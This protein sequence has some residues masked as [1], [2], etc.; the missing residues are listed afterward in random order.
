[1]QALSPEALRQHKGISFVGVT[2]CFLC[3][4]KDG[5]Y[6]MA[7]HSSRALD[8]AALVNIEHL[9]TLGSRPAAQR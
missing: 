4:N 6:F 3:Y 8:F 1:M 5:E 2:T 9:L 7:R